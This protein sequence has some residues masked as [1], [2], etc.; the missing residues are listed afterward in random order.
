MAREPTVQE[1]ASIQRATGALTM[2][3][4]RLELT[5]NIMI[6]LIYH[7]IG[8]RQIEPELPLMFSRRIRFLRRCFL[9]IE[10]LAPFRQEAV[11]VFD[12]LNH[13]AAMREHFS[14]GAFMGVGD[15]EFLS[16]QL[17]YAVF[18]PTPCKTLHRLVEQ[19][20]TLGDLIEIGQMADAIAMQASSLADSLAQTFVREEPGA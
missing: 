14:H 18:R 1:L 7:E 20:L 9:R 3:W 10:Q 6:A 13:L 17:N 4:G 19:T 5:L 11:E 2:R 15:G 12:L 16:L 8:G